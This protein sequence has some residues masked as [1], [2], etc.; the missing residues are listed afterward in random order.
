M[1]KPSGANSCTINHDNFFCFE[2]LSDAEQKLIEKNQLEVKFKKGEV[3]CKQGA[4]ATH[5]IFLKEG[6]GKV[7]IENNKE[8]LILRIMPSG[9]LL[10]LTSLLEGNNIFNYSVSAYKDSVV[11]MIDIKILREIIKKNS[12]FAFEIINIFCKN[13]M[14]INTRF[15]CLTHKQ[16]YGRLA[17]I[18]LCIACRIYKNTEFDFFFSR[19]ELAELCGI[20]S[21]S[22]IRILK[23]F[24]DDGLIEIK[25]KAFKILDY[26]SLQK[27]S[28]LG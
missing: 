7:Y 11:I 25:G 12:L 1:P 18:I 19:Q 17:D 14:Q 4:F 5:V 15:F 9:N 21:E 16:S 27:I 2:K 13:A 6:L 22:V 23:K 28:N 20:S 24:K 8:L 3:I 10:G 26:E